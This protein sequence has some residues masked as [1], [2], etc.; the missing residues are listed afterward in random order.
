MLPSRLDHPDPCICDKIWDCLQQEIRPRHKI[1]IENC[2]EFTP[3]HRQSC[4]ESSRLVAGPVGPADVLD[5]VSLFPIPF[6]QPR[7]DSHRLVGGVVKHLDLQF[8]LG[9][10][11][12]AGRVD[13][14]LYDIQFIEEGKL[15]SH[16]RIGDHFRRLSP[17][18]VP[19]FQIVV[20]HDET[21]QTEDKENGQR[22]DVREQYRHFHTRAVPR[23]LSIML[24]VSC[25]LPKCITSPRLSRAGH[26]LKSSSTPPAA[27]SAVAT[28]LPPNRNPPN[29]KSS[30]PT[31]FS[32][33][34]GPEK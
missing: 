29:S 1:R 32:A 22:D 16:H 6:H 13:E 5:V 12:G 20:D 9:I 27:R 31:F 8:L 28:D 23:L 19:E 3:R 24:V 26:P 25:F 33:S 2:Q 7:H 30:S 11:H 14:P 17:P 34:S 21:M 4:L 18:C 15:D 10:H